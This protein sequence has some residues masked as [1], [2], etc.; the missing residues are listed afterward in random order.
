MN[1]LTASS[2]YPVLKNRKN[3]ETPFFLLIIL[4]FSVQIFVSCYILKHSQVIRTYDEGNRI[5]GG[6]NMYRALFHDYEKTTA[7]K[8]DFL[9]TLDKGQSH[10]HFFEFAE[11]ACFRVLE[12]VGIIGREDPMILLANALFLLILILS[13]YGIGSLVYSRKVGFL[14][15]LVVSAFPFIFAHSRVAMLDFSLAS[16]VTLGFFLLLKT[17]NFH[18]FFYSISAGIAF[19]LAQLTKETAIIFI[20]PPLVYYSIR[21]SAVLAGKKKAALNFFFTLAFFALTGGALYL[22]NPHVLRR[23]LYAASRMRSEETPYYFQNFIDFTGTALL[24]LLLP[25]CLLYLLNIKKREKLF[26]FWLV[27]PFVLFQFSPNKHL[28]FIL[29]LLPAFALVASQEIYSNNLLRK[30][31]KACVFLLVSFSIM[32]YT[33]FNC[34]IMKYR[35]EESSMSKGVPAVQKDKYAPV[36]LAILDVFKKERPD[37]NGEKAVIPT[38]DIGEI[39]YSLNYKCILS[40]LPFRIYCTLELPDEKEAPLC[41]EINCLDVDYLIDK[42]QGPRWISNDDRIA[43]RQ[44]NLKEC[45]A[46]NKDCFKVIGEAEAPDGSVIYIYKNMTR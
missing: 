18:S 20:L 35:Y 40:R 44:K 8:L 14:A 46:K 25:L 22:K 32:Q 4:I 30:V 34:G 15:V 41:P 27:I 12:A 11:A 38:F 23:Y 7:A 21:S 28:R 33:L 42:P 17:D 13:V 6:W 16:L 24:L 19:G 3:K 31:R 29:P 37:G 26:F 43:V 39:R 10:P 36:V 2:L 1:K 9:F 45:L 5:C